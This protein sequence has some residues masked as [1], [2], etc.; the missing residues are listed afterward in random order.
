[1][2]IVCFDCIYSWDIQVQQK[3][4]F[5]DDFMIHD[6]LSSE[7]NQTT[8]PFKSTRGF[9]STRMMSGQQQEVDS[10]GSRRETQFLDPWRSMNSG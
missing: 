8:I 3:Q 5:H 10:N 1:M 7:K 2:S 9:S 4:S 6:S